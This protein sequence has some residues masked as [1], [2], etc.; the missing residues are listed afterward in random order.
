MLYKTLE[1]ITQDVIYEVS[2]VPGVAVQAYA[3]PIIQRKIQHHFDAVFKK[4]WWDQFYTPSLVV[5]Y[6]SHTG[7]PIN[8]FTAS[9]LIEGMDD[10]SFIFPPT[11]SKPLKRLPKHFN[12]EIISGTSPV[13]W[14]P[15]ASRSKLFRILPIPDKAMAAAEDTSTYSVVIGYRSH[16]NDY[17]TSDTVLFDSLYLMYSVCHDLLS[18]DAD[19][20]GDVEKFLQFKEERYAELIKN[21]SN[22]IPLSGQQ[23]T[24]PNDWFTR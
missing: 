15:Y 2:Q 3:E 23:S 5:Y 6:S 18:T 19:N 4:G 10:V 9:P 17:S 13:Y 16:P 12:R 24:I 8:D 14:E 21:T 7:L 1:T 20:P 11:G 22:E